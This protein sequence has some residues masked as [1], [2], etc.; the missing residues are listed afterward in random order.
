M[1]KTDK[2]PVTGTTRPLPKYEC[3]PWFIVWPVELEPERILARQRVLSS[4]PLFLLTLTTGAPPAGEPLQPGQMFA[5]A[6]VVADPSGEIWR[7]GILVRARA[8]GPSKLEVLLV[9]VYVAAEEGRISAQESASAEAE[10]L[11]MKELR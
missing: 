10:L 1:N 9:A 2:V 7:E 4:V 3:I 11:T 5:A 6:A 8:T